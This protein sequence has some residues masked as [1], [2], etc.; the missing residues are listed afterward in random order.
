MAKSL[1]YD[2]LWTRRSFYA[3][4]GW[5]EPIGA[6]EFRFKEMKRRQM[7]RRGKNEINSTCH[8]ARRPRSARLNTL[9]EAVMPNR[10]KDIKKELINK[11]TYTRKNGKR[12]KETT[13]KLHVL[14]RTKLEAQ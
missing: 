3:E 8:C 14:Q 1:Q 4:M 7:S 6:K 13:K 11:R 10:E 2:E 12:P 5:I 9:P